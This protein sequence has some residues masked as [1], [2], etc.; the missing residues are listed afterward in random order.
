V[1]EFLF[2]LLNLTKSVFLKKKIYIIS[3]KKVSNLKSSTKL[4]AK[5]SDFFVSSLKIK[6]KVI[7]NLKKKSDFTSTVQQYGTMYLQRVMII[8]YLLCFV[9]AVHFIIYML[10]FFLQ[11]IIKEYIKESL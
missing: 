6:K 4:K 1:V 9:V 7:M 3:K 2:L 10:L 11:Q 5:T 8:V